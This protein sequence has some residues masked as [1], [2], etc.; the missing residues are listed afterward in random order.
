MISSW[1]GELWIIDE[2]LTWG[3]SE[4]RGWRV[5]GGEFF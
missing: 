1:A 5:E 2:I 4:K 3:W